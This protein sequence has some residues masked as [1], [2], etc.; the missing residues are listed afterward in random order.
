MRVAN[1]DGEFV[2]DRFDFTGTVSDID[3]D[4]RINDT[5]TLAAAVANLECVGDDVGGR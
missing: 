4:G 1:A 2:S 5:P 3:L